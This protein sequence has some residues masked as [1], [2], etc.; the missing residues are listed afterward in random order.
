MTRSAPPATSPTPQ[1]LAPSAQALLQ[2]PLPGANLMEATVERLGTAIK[3]RLLEPGQQLPPERELAQLVGVSRVTLRSALRALQDGGFITARR[4]RAGGTF[5]AEAPPQWEP[6]PT[7]RDE[8]PP[9]NEG[10]AAWR[11]LV[12]PAVCEL[13]AMRMTPEL[14]QD[15]R[16]RLQR[17]DQLVDDLPRYRAE[18][19][20]LHIAIAEAT[21]NARMVRAVTEIQADLGRAIALLPPSRAALLHSNRQHAKLLKCLAGKD[22]QGARAAM[23]EHI[24]GTARFSAGL[25][26]AR[27]AS[28]K[29]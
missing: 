9:D 27:R 1:P 23:L 28:A 24:T 17:L 29:K 10:F 13:A 16:A 20:R 4:G 15:L 22:A 8:A 12:E 26:P 2:A 3:L 21:G 25:L 11:A 6:E 18:D 7:G 14:L 19:A 5:V